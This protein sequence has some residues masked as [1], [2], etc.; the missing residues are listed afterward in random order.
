MGRA[1]Y[2]VEAMVVEGR[3]P[4]E[5]ARSHGVARSW[6]YKLLAR[7]REG[8]YPALEARSRRPQRCP[9][10]TAPEL[11]AEVV[12]LRQELSEAGFDAGPQTILFHLQERFQERF[13]QLPSAATVWRILKRQGL[14]IPEP[15]KRPKAS[16]VRFEALL[17][18][19]T[20]QCDATQWQ[21]AD[22]SL[23]EIL[24]LEDDHSRLFLNSV[25]YPTVKAADV[26]EAFLSAADA[27]GF[28]ASFL[29]DNAAV[30]S[31]RSRRGKVALELELESRGI[32]VKHS[33]PYHPQTCGKVE[34]LHQTLK[35]FLAKQAPATSLALLQAQLDAFREYYN[36]RRPHRALGRQT[37]MAVFN[38]KL[39]A[40]PQPTEQPTHYRV[41]QDMIDAHG[42]VTLRY[43]GRLRHI[44]VGVLHRNRKVH[45]L[46]AGADVRIVTTGGE[47]LRE[48]R[49]DP[50]RLYFGLGGRWPVHNVLRQVS[51]MS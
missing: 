28:P 41:R 27:Y 15:H 47:L 26:V 45:L 2:L 31:G 6:L 50:D 43:L 51:S 38:A 30:F 46:V 20:W 39:K 11:E 7:F 1:R 5:L 36:Q 44:R 22:G 4:T 23:V 34:R 14:V 32:E 3:S 10:R 49:L 17:P 35:L 21:L 42:S 16:F 40:R 24:N 48:L 37:P 18:N 8:G 29:S 25:A 19:E 12:R 13:Q 33:T 9:R